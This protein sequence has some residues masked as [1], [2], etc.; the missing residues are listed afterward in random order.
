MRGSPGWVCP[1]D[2][3][4]YIYIYIYIYSWRL[5]PLNVK[6]TSHSMTRVCQR[7]FCLDEPSQGLERQERLRPRRRHTWKL[8]HLSHTTYMTHRTLAEASKRH[9]HTKYGHHHIAA[10]DCF[11]RFV[12]TSGEEQTFSN[13]VTKTPFQNT[14]PWLHQFWRDGWG[15]GRGFCR[16]APPNSCRCGRTH[17]AISTPVRGIKKTNAVKWKLFIFQKKQQITQVTFSKCNPNWKLYSHSGLQK[18]KTHILTHSLSIIYKKEYIIN[19][20]MAT[21]EK[22]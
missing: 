17:G 14:N 15:W 9:L 3:Y 6:Q 22:K 8:H 19:I 21:R 11:R 20:K 10:E 4:V 2:I 12:M 5:F 1:A 18:W 16:C 7:T 13:H